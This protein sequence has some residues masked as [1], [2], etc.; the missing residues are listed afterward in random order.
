MDVQVL[1]DWR[2]VDATQSRSFKKEEE[3]LKNFLKEEGGDGGRRKG[4][5]QHQR[6]PL[7][8]RLSPLRL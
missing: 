8:N 3:A 7:I 1:Q 4:E 5:V 6:L 2:V